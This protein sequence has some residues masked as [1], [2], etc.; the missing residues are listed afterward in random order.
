MASE[1]KYAEVLMGLGFDEISLHAAQLPKVKQV[2]R[3]TTTTEA[4]SLVDA[5][6]EQETAEAA[7][8]HLDAYLVEKK[9]RRKSKNR[10][11]R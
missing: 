1:T 7:A 5:L 3:W 4:A 9:A 10:E 11:T 2:I 6:L 8:A